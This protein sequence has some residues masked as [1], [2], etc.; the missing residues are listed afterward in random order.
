VTWQL[1]AGLSGDVLHQWRITICSPEL[2]P[3]A[4]RFECSLILG[5]QDVFKEPMQLPVILVNSVARVRPG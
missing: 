2:L 3:H 5:V 1:R 4:A